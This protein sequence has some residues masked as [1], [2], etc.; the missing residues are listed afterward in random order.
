[1]KTKKIILQL[2]FVITLMACS[3]TFVAQA[4]AQFNVLN[5]IGDKVD[6][7]GK[8]ATHGSS[9]GA[10][11]A[12]ELTSI[13][14]TV[15]DVVKYVAGTIAVTMLIIA[16][17]RLVTAGKDIEKISESQKKNIGYSI[18]SLIVI[19]LAD[20]VV[21]KVF[22]GETGDFL[23][24]ASNAQMY[25]EQGTTI[26]EGIYGFMTKF[27]A[28][29]AVLVIVGSGVGI[30]L[31]FG[32]EDTAKSH[33]NRILWALGALVLVGVAEFVVREILFPNKG[34]SLPSVDNTK[35]LVVQFTNFISGFIATIAV[36][37]LIY[38]G[39]L[40]VAD[41]GK[42]ENAKKAGTIIASAIIGILISLAAF[43]IVNS[44]VKLDRETII[45]PITTPINIAP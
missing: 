10:D 9:T 37:M 17:F 39:Y 25:A 40:Y 4:N 42:E 24:N 18:A 16:G 38:A 34:S 8:T 44:T 14:F 3:L 26:I 45:K 35:V 43:A 41:V 2:A 20:V 6:L 5:E 31:S 12:K 11:G 28:A 1:M 7:P 27:I 33:R 13:I 23:E 15:I 19:I 22:F 30:A 29:V 36:L 21:K 32:N